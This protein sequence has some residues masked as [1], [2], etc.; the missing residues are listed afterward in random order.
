MS[1]H[2][3][4]CGVAVCCAVLYCVVYVSSCHVT[5]SW[6]G[7]V[8]LCGVMLWWGVAC[9]VV[10]WS[11]V[12]ITGLAL[13]CGSYKQN[14]ITQKIK[15][16]FHDVDFHDVWMCFRFEKRQKNSFDLFLYSL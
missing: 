14:T 6:C 3:R 7:R 12:L 5:L 15:I 8:V 11:V 13:S 4:C 1:L 10:L 9:H 16:D 2:C